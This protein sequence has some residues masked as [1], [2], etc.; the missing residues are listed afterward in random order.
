MF[1]DA[2]SVPSMTAGYSSCT[3]NTAT[4]PPASSTSTVSSGHMPVATFASVTSGRRVNANAKSYR[5]MSSMIGSL[6]LCRACVPE[7]SGKRHDVNYRDD[8]RR[9][10]D[11]S[12]IPVTLL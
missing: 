3:L 9:G 1:P 6:S 2:V 11:V 5:L 8:E 4:C 12:V 7:Q 10:L